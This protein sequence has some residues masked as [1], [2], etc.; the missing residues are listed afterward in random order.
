MD[1][2]TR[3]EFEKSQQSNPMGSLMGGGGQSGAG[4]FDVA[5][6]LSGHNK[7]GGGADNA[8]E[9]PAAGGG[10]SSSGKKGGRR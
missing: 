6:F 3:A 4:N 7:G 10:S 9:P 1:P 8:A 2:E 5:G